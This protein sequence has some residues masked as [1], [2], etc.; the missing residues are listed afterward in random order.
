[1]SPVAPPRPSPA[2][3]APAADARTLRF[4]EA[5]PA[6]LGIL[7]H[8]SDHDGRDALALLTGSTEMLN[9]ARALISSTPV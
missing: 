7:G 4:G 9:D 1:M 3:R 6:G 2:M 8:P 5:F